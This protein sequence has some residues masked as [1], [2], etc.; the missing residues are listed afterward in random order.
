MKQVQ[1]PGVPDDVIRRRITLPEN[2]IEIA[3]QD[4]GGD[5]PLALLHHANGFCAALWAPV[6]EC[7]RDRFHV[8]AMDARGHG[9]SGIPSE[10][11]TAETFS[12]SAMGDDVRQVANVL[13]NESGQSEIAL[14]LGH[15]FGG[16]LTLA[17][18]SQQPGL[19]EKLVLIDPVVPP[20][21]WLL[22]ARG[23]NEN[24]MV[25]RAL[26]RRDRWPSREE[27]RNLLSSKA[28]FAE[29]ESRAYE[30]Y[31]QE[32]L[33]ETEGGEVELK[34]AREVEAAVFGNSFSLDLEKVLPRVAAQVR[35]IWAAQGSFPL[36]IVRDVC[37]QL[38]RGEL[39]ELDAGHLMLMEKPDWVVDHVLSFCS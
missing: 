3:L 1:Y 33:Q 35:L 26:R 21:A 13:L 22:E 20:P 16:T 38:P 7:L 31:I 37:N 36:Q 24:Q 5:G 34:C 11:V 15:S 39:I 23:G 30:L 19:Y 12:W 28:L 9:D 6:A 4:W 32:A 2:G 29:W 17:A 27:A 14:G 18:E 10:V 25:E 8:V